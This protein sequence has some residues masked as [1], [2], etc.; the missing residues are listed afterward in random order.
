MQHPYY[1]GIIYLLPILLLGLFCG[2]A[3]YFNNFN[4]DNEFKP[5]FRRLVASA[6]TSIISAVAIFTMLDATSFSYWFKFGV[7][8]LVAF[9][10]ID[11]ALE[12][13]IKVM[14]GLR[15]GHHK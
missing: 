15:G 10:G 11:R 2:V 9:F 14:N 13:A 8:A 3:T 12:Y 1:D 5:S 7:S 4:G 6:T